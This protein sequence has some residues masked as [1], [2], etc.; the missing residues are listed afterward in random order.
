[1]PREEGYHVQGETVIVEIIDAEGRPCPPGVRGRAIV[2]PLHNFA[3]PLLRYEVGD[4]AV[5]GDPCPCG[6]GLPVIE[7]IVGRIRSLLTL[8]TGEHVTPVFVHDL[9]RDLPVIQFQVAQV[10]PDHLETRIVPQGSFGPDDEARLI[11]RMLERLPADYRITF[12][13]IEEI[14]RSRSG[15]YMDFKSEIVPEPE[16]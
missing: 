7:R 5:A 13:Y 16:S 2:T 12:R 6:R 3:M 11:E 10:A 14:P 9:M 15:K 4:E 1:M 8:P